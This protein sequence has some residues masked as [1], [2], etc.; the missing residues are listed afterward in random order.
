MSG[1]LG[2][3]VSYPTS[4]LSKISEDT[5]VDRVGSV[6]SVQINMD[7]RK[8][9]IGPLKRELNFTEL[10]GKHYWRQFTSVTPGN[11]NHFIF[12]HLFFLHPTMINVNFNDDLYD[13]LN[14]K[15]RIIA[16][17][18]NIYSIFASGNTI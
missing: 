15:N 6:T 17:H 14:W 7:R 5:S 2:K 8:S 1:E 3:G 10:W 4:N 9:S 12:F 16:T 18:I 11:P 13:I